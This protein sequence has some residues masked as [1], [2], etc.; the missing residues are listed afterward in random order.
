MTLQLVDG[1]AAAASSYAFA[2][3]F[4]LLVIVERIVHAAGLLLL[5]LVHTHV[6][7]RHPRRELLCMVVQHLKDELPSS[8]AAST[9]PSVSF[10]H[11]LDRWIDAC[12]IANPIYHYDGRAFAPLVLGK[13]SKAQS[14]R[15]DKSS[16]EHL[17]GYASMQMVG[18]GITLLTTACTAV[19]TALVNALSALSSYVVWAVGTTLVFSVL[20]IVQENYSDIL[21][22]AVDQWNAAYGPLLHKIVFV[23]LQASD[24]VFSS[25]VPL[26][27]SAIWL[28]RTLIHDVGLDAL[29]AN[30]PSIRQLGA[31]VGNVVQSSALEIP[32]YVTS[33]ASSC[34]FAQLGDLCYDPGHNCMVDLISIMASVLQMGVAMSMIALAL[35]GRA[36]APVNM[37]LFPLLNI[38]LAKSMHNLVNAVLYTVLQLPSVTAQRCKNHG[39]FSSSSPQQKPGP[40]ANATLSS[41]AAPK[42]NNLQAL[43]MC[44]LDFNPPIKHAGD[45]AAKLGRSH[46]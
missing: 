16:S 6:Q 42:N 21:V 25:L 34:D 4:F 15:R 27:N 5:R 41:S 9:S 17:L 18:A 30:V 3:A 22:D 39:P 11:A 19:L 29:V 23:P 1:S 20:Y 40:Q 26:Y 28:A 46:Q 35:C 31:S 8:P 7:R 32:P 13:S 38:N 44:L 24:V 14:L 33:L 36:A 43:V 45:G 12:L 37:V 2:T 10:S